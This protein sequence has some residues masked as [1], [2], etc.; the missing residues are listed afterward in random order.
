M[1]KIIHACLPVL[2][3]AGAAT[4]LFRLDFSMKPK[5]PGPGALGDAMA[6]GSE[7]D[8]SERYTY[9]WQRLHDPATGRIP[10]HIREKELA[11]AATLPS[12]A[13]LFAGKGASIASWASRGPWNVGGRTRAFGVD[14]TNDSILI[15]GSC[16]GGMW[17]SAD[18]G[19]SWSITTTPVQH[20]STSCLSQDVRPGHTNTWYAGSGEAYGASA[21][22]GGG[23]Y[24]LGNGIYKSTD[25]GL[26]WNSLPSTVSGTPQSFDNIW[27][28][29][30]NVKTYPADTVNDVVFAA[31]YGAI[32]RSADGG[33]TWSK[34]LGNPTSAYS[35]FTDVEVTPSG[36]V[37][38]TLSDD[39]PAKGIWRSSDGITFTNITPSNF[40]SAY[41][42]IVIG[43][44]PSDENQ[45]Y[46]L[47]NTPGFGQPDT[48]FLGTVEWN[49][50][51]KYQYLSGNG[52][53]SGGY[54]FDRS[55]NLP[56]TGGP[57]D[58]FQCQGSYDLLVQVKP[59]DT[60][61][62]FI[63][64][65]NLYRSTSAFADDTHTTFIG[66]YEE[67]ATLPVVNS[68]ADHHPDQHVLVFRPSNPDVMWSANDGGIFKTTDNTA[69]VVSWTSLNNGY[70]TGMFYTV[71]LD[72]AAT[73]NDIVIAGAQDNGSWYTNS[74]SPTTPWVTPR[75]GDGS[76]CA[77]ADNQTAY[78]F[79][80]QNGKMMKATLDPSGQVD[81]FARIDPLGGTGYQFINPYVLDPNNNNLMYLAG[82]KYLWR[83]N[84][85]SGI[86][87][88]SN[89]DSIT[90]NW[91]MFP[92]S[93]PVANVNI[94]AVAVSKAPANRVY[95]GTS[96]KRVYRIDN[97]NTG[98]PV[99]V[100]ITSTTTGNLFPANGNV[101]CI[102]VDPTDA[103]KL[104]VVFSNYS[105]YSLFY[106]GDGGSTWTKAGGN[107]EFNSVGGG[108]GPSLR[109]ASIMPVSNGTVYLVA[110]S[111]GL[112]A[113]SALNGLSTVWVQQGA[114]T[115]GNAV[116]D[117]IDFRQGDGRVVVATHSHG[118]YSSVITDVNDVAGLD[119]LPP[120]GNMNLEV[121]PNPVKEQAS[122]TI[123]MDQPAVI[124]LSLYDES[125]RLIRELLNGKE[126]T[127][128][129][130]ISFSV[131]QL[132]PG[133]YYLTLRRAGSSKS[134]S[135]I[136]L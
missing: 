39:G 136:R 10:D 23:A 15:A 120:A 38:A 46:F 42:R 77:I 68:Y 35:Y 24:Y 22:A 130:T 101:S 121:F 111:T 7:E 84:D 124:T 52:S 16:S 98:S 92:D 18:G 2:M 94:T 55:A 59:N 129:K 81:S 107:L 33:T 96:N 127:G 65:T 45:V 70:L 104:L 31:T 66:G 6:I 86:P 53:G 126:Q 105:V 91:F 34:V 103:D 82:G 125:G 78:Y 48:N 100:E 109:W 128:T 36:A 64:G 106:S 3:L 26:S 29:I 118:I 71:A 40:P 87:Y 135:F 25:G 19:Q 93:V 21:S 116:C 62:V 122:V 88:A 133:I 89:W 108:N 115:I 12:D 76:Y 61:T 117:M 30:W 73:G 20:L 79:S 14:V 113:T 60:N 28:L 99:P 58:K 17:R 47:A 119:D 13:S 32:Y 90:T 27:D 51:W 9:E 63:G 8:A 1:K 57:F 67:G 123:H 95:F 110:S 11:F 97:A 5:H 50:L 56:T 132:R 114:N 112:Y 74:T 72:H 69:P 49:S 134:K 131:S 102:A 54:W 37:Y 44:A 80:I 43:Y 41:N 85:L 75:G 83:N 4:F